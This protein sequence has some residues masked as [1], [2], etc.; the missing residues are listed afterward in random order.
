MY[1]VSKYQRFEIYKPRYVLTIEYIS[2]SKETLKWLL[3]I[4]VILLQN[5]AIAKTTNCNFNNY[6][7]KNLCETT[8][9]EFLYFTPSLKKYGK[10]ALLSSQSNCSYF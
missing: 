6:F 7:V 8:E 4:R 2:T 5:S 3:N 1:H 10:Y 9:F